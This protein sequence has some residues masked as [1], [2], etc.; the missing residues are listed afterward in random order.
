MSTQYS[1]Q[2]YNHFHPLFLPN[3]PFPAPLSWSSLTN[4]QKAKSSSAFW[5]AQLD[6]SQTG[7]LIDQAAA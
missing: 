3:L 4:D 6:F 1:H 2:N 7:V 5:T